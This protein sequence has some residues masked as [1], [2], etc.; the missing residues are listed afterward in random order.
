MNENPVDLAKDIA[1]SINPE[2]DYSHVATWADGRLA[3]LCV[4]LAE[5]LDEA[6]KRIK[7]LERSVIA[8]GNNEA[9]I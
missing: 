6:E 3:L 2:D 8:I 1:D 4:S 7:S 5:R 9:L